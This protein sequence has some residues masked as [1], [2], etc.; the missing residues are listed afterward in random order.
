M[1]GPMV[2]FLS[3]GTAR[4]FINIPTRGQ[5]SCYFI[6]HSPRAEMGDKGVTNKSPI[7]EYEQYNNDVYIHENTGRQLMDM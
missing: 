1:P 6:T 4:P 2:A 7:I 3:A 5:H